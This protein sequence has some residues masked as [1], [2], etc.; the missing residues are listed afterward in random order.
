MLV[1]F[2]CCGLNLRESLWNVASRRSTLFSV[3]GT[4]TCACTIINLVEILIG[5]DRQTWCSSSRRMST[6]SATTSFSFGLLWFPNKA[7]LN[8]TSLWLFFMM[9][10]STKS[11]SFA[12]SSQDVFWANKRAARVMS[13]TVNMLNLTDSNWY[14]RDFQLLWP[15]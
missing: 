12:K 1:F 8:I 5:R 13:G 10:W 15:S 14:L 3:R 2:F 6:K 7:E 11:C 4:D 9:P